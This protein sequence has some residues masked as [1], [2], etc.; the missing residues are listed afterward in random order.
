MLLEFLLDANES[1]EDGPLEAD[2]GA[3]A[4]GEGVGLGHFEFGFA[5]LDVACY[6]HVEFSSLR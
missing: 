1:G 4:A 5:S 2:A 3:I 6:V